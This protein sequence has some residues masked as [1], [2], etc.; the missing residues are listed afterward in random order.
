MNETPRYMSNFLTLIPLEFAKW[1][2][3][4]ENVWMK[5]VNSWQKTD[6]EHQNG[7]EVSTTVFLHMSFYHRY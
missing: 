5:L 6:H 1:S 3:S 2:V 7:W 4:G